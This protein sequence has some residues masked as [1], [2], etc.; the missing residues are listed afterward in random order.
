MDVGID[1]ARTIDLNDPVY[2]REV[3]ATSRD[4]GA[5]EE[6]VLGGR[7]AVKGG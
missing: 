1:V 2:G 5:D 3:E 4:I 7:E 6:S